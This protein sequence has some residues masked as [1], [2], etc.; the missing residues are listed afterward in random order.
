MCDATI[1]LQ[2]P[3]S[4]QHCWQQ[5]WQQQHTSPAH[6]F[7][8]HARKGFILSFFLSPK[9]T[10][11]HTL[12]LRPRAPNLEDPEMRSHGPL[13]P[14][15]ATQKAV[16]LDGAQGTELERRGLDLSHSHL[17]SSQLLLDDPAVIREASWQS[18]P[19][20]TCNASHTCLALTVRCNRHGWMC[21][22]IACAVEAFSWSLISNL[23]LN[24]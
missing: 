20:M 24:S 2:Q 5:C 19:N 11:I 16:I 3:A 18:V 4:F 12:S 22:F 9:G 23:K 7:K 14:F 1:L 17:W 6:S 21:S 8:S 13:S 10:R 15:L